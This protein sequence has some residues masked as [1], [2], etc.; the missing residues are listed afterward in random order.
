MEPGPAV[1]SAPPGEEMRVR[2][3]RRGLNSTPWM[4]KPWAG[5]GLGSMSPS[6]EVTGP[7]L[8]A[9]IRN[10]VP[11]PHGSRRSPFGTPPPP[12]PHIVETVI[13]HGPEHSDDVPRPE[14]QLCLQ[15]PQCRRQAGTG[16]VSTPPCL[17]SG[18]GSPPRPCWESS[19]GGC[20]QTRPP[21]NGELSGQQR[22]PVE[23]ALEGEEK[24]TSSRH[25]HP[26]PVLGAGDPPTQVGVAA[27]LAAV[28]PGEA[29]GAGKPLTSTG[30][31]RPFPLG[32]GEKSP[33][34]PAPPA[35][36]SG[37]R[38]RWGALVQGK[39]DAQ[40]HTGTDAGGPSAREQTRPMGFT[41]N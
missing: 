27:S 29:G 13:I 20:S 7:S 12:R 22:R 16:T 14:G 10:L 35:L 3:A 24:T 8:W 2:Q 28:A 11:L 26:P 34:S 21:W 41:V 36:P 5:D 17:G 18:R 9:S 23:G 37:G 33:V 40:P 31:G 1:H 19:P 4:L 30:L 38:G 6:R 32:I 15:R 25:S 39:Q